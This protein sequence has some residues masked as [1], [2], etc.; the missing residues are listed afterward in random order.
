MNGPAPACRLPAVSYLGTRLLDAVNTRQ[1]RARHALHAVRSDPLAQSE[2]TITTVLAVDPGR[3]K[4]GLAVV[5]A[6][7]GVLH[8]RVVPAADLTCAVAQLVEEYDVDR[9][10]VGDRT[11][12]KEIHR[13]LSARV[14]VRTV[15]V[16]E[17][18][19]SEQGRRRYF[20]DNPPRGWR[21]LLPIGL[22]TPPRA[23]D[24]YVAVILAERYLASQRR[25]K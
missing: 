9:V 20:H 5:R 11:A 6:D 3:D 19:S 2:Q 10:L 8:Q 16:D 23:Y 7:G 17:H 18:R 12:A 13:A 1:R 24:D 21:R 14:P 22:Q 25:G 4:C 15:L